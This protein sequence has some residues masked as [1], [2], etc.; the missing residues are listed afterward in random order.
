VISSV[1]LSGIDLLQSLLQSMCVCVCQDVLFTADLSSLMWRPYASNSYA[2]SSSCTD[3][4]FSGS[5]SCTDFKRT[6]WLRDVSLPVIS[7]YG[8]F[9]KVMVICFKIH[10]PKGWN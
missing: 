3:G 7:A 2:E 4:K 1:V 5:S 6:T 9:G 8:N 10:S